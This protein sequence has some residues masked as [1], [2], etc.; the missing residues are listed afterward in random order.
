MGGTWGW[1]E[2]HG[3]LRLQQGRTCTGVTVRPRMGAPSSASANTCRPG[4]ERP[5]R[6]APPQSP[7]LNPHRTTNKH[8]DSPLVHENTVSGGCHLRLREVSSSKQ[9][10]YFA[11]GS[12]LA[13]AE[14][15]DLEP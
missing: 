3:F 8:H 13:K 11:G 10:S 12:V 14:T 5:L 4:T 2:D 6:E 1:M 7:S 15:V 9:Q